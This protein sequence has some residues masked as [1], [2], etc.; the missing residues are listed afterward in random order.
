M[1]FMYLPI[2]V[3]LL[4]LSIFSLL[5]KIKKSPQLINTIIGSLYYYSTVILTKNL[6]HYKQLQL[7]WLLT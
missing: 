5:S 1:G 7:N 6:C 2:I 3:V 4:L